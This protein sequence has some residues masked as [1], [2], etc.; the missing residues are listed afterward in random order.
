M[1]GF[2]DLDSIQ[3]SLGFRVS[4]LC[5][6]GGLVKNLSIHY[7]IKIRIR[8]VIV[9]KMNQLVVQCGSLKG[10]VC[11]SWGVDNLPYVLN[12]L[13]Q[14]KIMHKLTDVVETNNNNINSTLQYILQN[15]KFIEDI[16]ISVSAQLFLSDPDT[17]QRIKGYRARPKFVFYVASQSIHRFWDHV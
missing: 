17:D 1:Q 3:F 14:L 10:G 13:N 9:N 2:S 7:R 11:K 8:L 5:S 4:D 16:I 6:K 15:C 12:P